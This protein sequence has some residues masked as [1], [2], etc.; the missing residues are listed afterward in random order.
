V[1]SHVEAN[2]G[3]VRRRLHVIRVAISET[4]QT[5]YELAQRVYAATFTP[6]SAPY[7]LTKML[8]YLTHL[9][10]IGEAVRVTGDPERWT[11]T[12]GS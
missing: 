11:A 12:A 10:T 2:R 7:K 8:C 9:E 3:L 4:P 1:R 5:A 6:E